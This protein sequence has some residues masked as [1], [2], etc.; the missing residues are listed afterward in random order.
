MLHNSSVDV[1]QSE[2]LQGL[3]LKPEHINSLR[4]VISACFSETNGHHESTNGSSHSAM[5]DNSTLSLGEIV[6]R[7]QNHIISNDKIRDVRFVSAEEFASIISQ[8]C[9]KM[10][11]ATASLLAAN[12]LRLLMKAF[13]PSK[14][15]G[16]KA[17][18]STVEMIGGQTESNKLS[19]IAIVAALSIYESGDAFIDDHRSLSRASVSGILPNGRFINP[20]VSRDS[21]KNR[22]EK[23][24]EGGN[25]SVEENDLGQRAICALLEIAAYSN[26]HQID[27][28]IVTSLVRSFRSRSEALEDVCAT[29]V[30]QAL[31]IPKSD[32]DRTNQTPRP[33]I[34]KKVATAAFGLAAEIGPW[35]AMSCIPLINMCVDMELWQAA[36]RMCSSAIQR[37]SSE[38]EDAVIVLMDHAFDQHMYRRADHLATEFYDYGGESRFAEAR[39][40]HACETISKVVLKRQFPIIE[41]QVERVDKAIDR[42]QTKTE[43]LDYYSIHEEC[44]DLREAKVKLREFALTRLRE[45]NVHETAHRLALL[46]DME[47]WYDYDDAEKYVQARREKYIQWDDAFPVK[48]GMGV[49]DVPEVLSTHN[50]LLCSFKDLESTMNSKTPVIGFDV[51]WGDDS[52]GAA[53][54]QLSTAK[55]SI[56][57]DIPALGKYEDG[58][59]ALELTVGRIFGSPTVKLLGFSCKE[60][61]SR[62]RGSPSIRKTHWFSHNTN[63]V[64]DIKPLI[65]IDNPKLRSLGLSRSSEHYIGKPLDKSEQCSMWGQRPLSESQRT[66]AAL[67][68]WACV[69]IYDKL[70]FRG[71]TSSSSTSTKRKIYESGL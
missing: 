42:V 6:S 70:S 20:K 40:L 2:Q 8:E 71:F 13:G 59:K 54:L 34:D 55:M 33:K 18:I 38:V 64:V 3:N 39:F 26:Q 9:P 24:E 51:E 19:T 69:A 37:G 7:A 57:I 4:Q 10:K 21:L 36:E 49:I 31:H 12:S 35:K 50:E 1:R 22:A 65:S 63:A 30:R 11:L 61:L 56:L 29:V 32:D 45:A 16:R 67:D 58:C 28:H 43:S 47:Y 27:V 15:I 14:G 5:L 48:S 53:L 52:K 23:V 46:W 68:A 25:K 66:Y 44:E 41:R 17:L 62:L 60:D